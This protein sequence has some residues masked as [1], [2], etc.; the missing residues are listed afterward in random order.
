MAT[1]YPQVVLLGDSLIEFS[2]ISRDGFSFHN[3][4]QA[5]LIR[6]YDVVNRGLSGWNTANVLKYFAEIFPEPHPYSPKIEYLVILLGANDAALPLETVTQHVPIDEYKENLHN[7]INHPH[8][9][10]HEPKILLVTPPPVDE[11]KLTKLDMA[12]GHPSACRTSGVT[13]KYAEKAREV[14][15]ENLGVVL[16]DLWQAIMT[17]AI[18][19]MTPG[20]H[21]PEGPLLGSLEN[22]KQGGL[23]LLLHDGLHMGAEG[24]KIFYNEIQS[25][26]GKGWE[27]GDKTDYHLPDWRIVNPAKVA[28]PPTPMADD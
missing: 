26:I 17:T 11:I 16:V 6:R 23:D 10:A 3:T 13:A 14:A 25:H 18:G 20:D 8:I 27:L 9:K 15:R 24:Y 2:V 12:S 1:S 21:R 28:F 7:I 4:L 22:G 19:M 5:S